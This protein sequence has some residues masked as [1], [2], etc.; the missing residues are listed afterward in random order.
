MQPGIAEIIIHG[1]AAGCYKKNE[2]WRSGKLLFTIT[3]KAKNVYTDTARSD[4]HN[5]SVM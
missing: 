2:S 4:R 5:A 3:I 1:P